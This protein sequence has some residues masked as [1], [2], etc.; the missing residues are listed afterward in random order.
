VTAFLIGSFFAIA[1]HSIILLFARVLCTRTSLNNLLL[2]GF[3]G[4]F[5]IIILPNA[6]SESCTQKSLQDITLTG[7]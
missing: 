1:F 5:P 4:L 3:I 2:K 6:L 7:F